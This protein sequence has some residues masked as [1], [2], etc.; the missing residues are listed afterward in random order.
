MRPCRISSGVVARMFSDEIVDPLLRSTV[1]WLEEFNGQV[2]CVSVMCDPCVEG[3]PLFPEVR[4][5][6][7]SCVSRVLTGALFQ[8]STHGSLKSLKSGDCWPWVRCL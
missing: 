7:W 4:S 5:L 6:R 2:S 1:S 3:T 8:P